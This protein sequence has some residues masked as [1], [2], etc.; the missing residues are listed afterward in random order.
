MGQSVEKDPPNP[1]VLTGCSKF[2]LRGPHQFNS[3]S[4]YGMK[5]QKGLHI[6]CNKLNTSSANFFFVVASTWLLHLPL[7][8]LS[9]SLALLSS[10]Q[11]HRTMV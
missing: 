4:S 5:N 11:T 1:L 3:P 7:P 8:L 2:A 9:L 6:Y 10:L